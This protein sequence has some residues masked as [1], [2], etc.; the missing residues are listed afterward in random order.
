MSQAPEIL[1]I[2]ELPEAQQET[3]RRMLGAILEKN[4]LTARPLM[5]DILEYYVSI[6]REIPEEIEVAYAHLLILEHAAE[7]QKTPH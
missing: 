2:T 5:G 4:H 6:E 1:P 3:F 7:S